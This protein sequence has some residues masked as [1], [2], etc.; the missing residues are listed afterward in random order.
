MN[1]PEIDRLAGEVY[2]SS[3]LFENQIL[4]LKEAAHLLKL[5]DKKMYQLVKEGDVPFKR[6]GRGIRFSLV[7]LL[8]WMK[9]G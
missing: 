3:L 9:G 4:T 5:S 8:E 7:Q 2:D 1:E 6:I